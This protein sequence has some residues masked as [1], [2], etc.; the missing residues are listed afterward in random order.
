[1]PPPLSQA[2]VLHALETHS[3]S[4]RSLV[5]TDMS[6]VVTVSADGGRERTPTLTGHIAFDRELPGLW[7]SAE[8]VGRQIF[9]LKARGDSF[10]LA[11]PETREVA[12]GSSQAYGKIPY[13]VRPGE[14][15]RLLTGIEGLGL[16]WPGT[17]MHVED[18]HYRFDVEVLGGPYAQVLVDRRKLVVSAIRRYDAL[19][20]IVTEVRLDDYRQVGR[21]L[22]AH[23]FSVTRPLSG[24]E[25][26]L[27]LGGPKLNKPIPT[28]AFQPAERPGW[29][30][31]DLDRQPLSAVRAFRKE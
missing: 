12:T 22:F 5:D 21:K 26:A 13:L 2:E 15:Q 1:M 29:D 27:R 3:G 9:S 30:I 6:L 23:R 10:W 8:K 20:R 11:L 19:G 14:A 18:R 16:R 24:T 25:V 4:F 31:I 28:E 7:I 17:T